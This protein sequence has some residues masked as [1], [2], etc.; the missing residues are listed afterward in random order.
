MSLDVAMPV[1]HLETICVVKDMA[2]TLNPA[3][4][5]GISCDLLCM[6]L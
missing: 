3:D 5:A 2:P 6:N 4:V 1:D